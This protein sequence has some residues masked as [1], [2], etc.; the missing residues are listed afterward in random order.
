MKI[1][2]ISRG[3]LNLF[4]PTQGA[5]VKLF[6]TLINLSNSGIKTFFV[7]AENN[8]YYEIK[9]GNFVKKYYPWLIKKSPINIFH[10]KIMSWLGLSNDIFVLYHPIINLGLW[11]KLFYVVLKEKIDL[12]QAEFTAFGVPALIIKSVTSKPVIL[13]EHNIESFQ[14]P[15][16]TN[17]SKN[18]WKIIKII[19]KIVCKFS[20]KI[21][22]MCDE[23]KK[24]LE[25]IG[26]DK[27]KI[28]IIPHG[29]DLKL[30]KKLISGKI[31][32]KYELKFP[33]LVFHGVYSYKPNYQA[34]KIISK[35]IIPKL[36]KEGIN[37]KLLA[38]GDFPPKDINDPNIIFTGVVHFKN[39]PNYINAGDIA[40]VPLQE[41]GGIRMKILEYFA[42]KVPV[43]STKKG[44][45]GIGAKNG[46]EIIIT[47]IKDFPN[48]ILKLI[49][50]NKFRKKMTKKAFKFV[51][52]YDWKSVCQE[53]IN[54]Y[55][56][57]K[58]KK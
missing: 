29:V 20:D 50:S 16:I 39:L 54:I 31:K 57:F 55:K 30:Y 51:E 41:G 14:L 28:Y 46:E 25:K 37:A 35:K 15:T 19:E 48:Q 3:D 22:V 12:I 53:Y 7:S 4:P 27:N 21:I 18:G 45:E 38:I 23:E 8:Y 58:E 2:L 32:K 44:V 43:I 17:L 10:K 40:I 49:N 5:S 56:N 6:Y 47:D 33:T 34:I 1:C 9:R 24:K 11:I 42:A 52:N 13:V 26:I 36:R